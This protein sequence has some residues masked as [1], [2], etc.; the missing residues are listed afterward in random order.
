MRDPSITGLTGAEAI[1]V[2]SIICS[3]IFA[4]LFRSRNNSRFY[5]LYTTIMDIKDHLE[6]IEE[7][8]KYRF[9]KINEKD[10][11]EEVHKMMD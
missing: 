3:I 11:A 2:A 10:L 8:I 7:M 4:V 9:R 6:S 1:A 5:D